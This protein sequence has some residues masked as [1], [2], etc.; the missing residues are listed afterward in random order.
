VP[1]GLYSYVD[2][3]DLRPTVSV[4]GADVPAAPDSAGYVSLDRRWQDGDVIVVDLPM[5]VRRVMADARVPHTRGRVAIERGP[6][7]Y[8]AEWPEA[9]DGRVLDALLEPAAALAVTVDEHAFGGVPVIKTVA[10]RVSNPA[11][12]AR[13]LTLIPYYLWANRG[14][15][16][17]SVWLST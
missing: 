15:G 6:I 2:A 16:E 5:A 8:C 3:V 7:V 11:S 4:N 17:M 12:P 1:G 13:P 14:A 9:E 10:R